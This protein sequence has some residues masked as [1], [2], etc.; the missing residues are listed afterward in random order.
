VET[1][2]II[3]LGALTIPS[4]RR[5][6]INNPGLPGGRF[7]IGE[8]P[9]LVSL[10]KRGA[11]G[12]RRERFSRTATGLMVGA[13]TV[14][15]TSGFAAATGLGFGTL[16]AALRA[17]G[18][19]GVP[20]EAATGLTVAAVAAAG[21]TAAVPPAGFAAEVVVEAVFAEGAAPETGFG[22]GEVAVLAV[23]A[24]VAV[25][26][27]PAEVLLAGLAAVVELLAGLAAGFAVAVPA[28]EFRVATGFVAEVAAAGAG[29]AAAGA[30]EAAF[31]LCV[32]GAAVPAGVA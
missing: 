29:F 25:D 11:K 9:P 30:V 17:A 26:F 10:P 24:D 1:I 20:L 8:P 23:V 32:F 5:L 15:G 14:L 12:S 28:A 2:A 18:R 19:D 27:G 31:G 7:P 13:V 22:A 6:L 16:P 21:F 3:P 4:I